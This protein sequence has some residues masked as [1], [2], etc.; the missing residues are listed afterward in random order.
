MKQIRLI[1]REL[2]KYSTWHKILYYIFSIIAFIALIGIAFNVVHIITF[3][4]S[5]FFAQVINKECKE[6]K[7]YEKD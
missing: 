3:A 7:G 1:I 4:F 5:A 2:R 6:I